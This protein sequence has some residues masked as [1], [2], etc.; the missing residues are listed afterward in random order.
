[1]SI[2]L[3]NYIKNSFIL[4]KKINENNSVASSGAAISLAIIALAG[5]F[6]YFHDRKSERLKP[7]ITRPAEEKL[8]KKRKLD[9]EYTFKPDVSPK[10]FF[11]G[12][13][14][15]GAYLESMQDEDAIYTVLVKDGDIVKI[16]DEFHID[17]SAVSEVEEVYKAANEKLNMPS[18]VKSIGFDYTNERAFNLKNFL[19]SHDI[20]KSVSRESVLYIIEDIENTFF[21]TDL[22]DVAKNVNIQIF[23]N[24]LNLVSML[25]STEAVVESSTERGKELSQEALDDYEEINNA[26]ENYFSTYRDN[27]K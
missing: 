14:L 19:T 23:Y 22:K 4:K 9:K 21:A 13:D 11:Y 25:K 20:I 17:E 12:K 10:D 15:D 6:F 8:D 2:F 16:V 26:V 18:S 3:E 1:M 7:S 5:A 24:Y 27:I